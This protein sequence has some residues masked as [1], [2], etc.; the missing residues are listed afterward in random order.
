MIYNRFSC[1]QHSNS[2]LSIQVSASLS[3]LCH[4]FRDLLLT[5]FFTFF[6]PSLICRQVLSSVFFFFGHLLFPMLLHNSHM[7]EIILYLLISFWLMLFSMILSNSIY[8]AANCM[9]SYI[10][11]AEYTYLIYK[12]NI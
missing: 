6:V 3:S 12:Y 1:I 7:I 2:I 9:I 4:C 11:I 10:I 5:T 8:I